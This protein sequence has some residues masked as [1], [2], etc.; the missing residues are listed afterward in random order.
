MKD[1]AS[2]F[3][4]ISVSSKNLLKPPCVPL[5]LFTD[6]IIQMDEMS[7]A[8]V[9]NAH[10]MNVLTKKLYFFRNVKTSIFQLSIPLQLMISTN[11]LIS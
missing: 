8:V 9:I 3:Y 11:E 6:F 5:S 10:N 7:H 2:I 1:M 4:Q